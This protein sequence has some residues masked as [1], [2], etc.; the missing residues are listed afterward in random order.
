MIDGVNHIGIAVRDLQQAIELYGKLFNVTDF[1]TE[2]VED[3]GVAVASFS[4]GS[5][6]IELT[7]ATR[8]DSPIAK[9]IDKKGE[10]IHHIAFHSTNLDEDLRDKQVHG[11]ELIDATPRPGAHDMMIAFLHPK[12]TGGVLMELCSEKKS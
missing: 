4:V 2:T 10:G 7:A 11:V 1:H 9:F 12:S 6:R 8:P 5:V 3:Q